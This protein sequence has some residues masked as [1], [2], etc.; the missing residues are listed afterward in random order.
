MIIW[1]KNRA[2]SADSVGGSRSE[3][4]AKEP[5]RRPNAGYEA[6]PTLPLAPTL[7]PVFGLKDEADAG[8]SATSDAGPADTGM[9]IIRNSLEAIPKGSALAFATDDLGAL[10]LAGAPVVRAPEFYRQVEHLAQACFCSLS[11]QAETG[12]ITFHRE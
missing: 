8:A 10:L 1:G 3:S 7:A 6:L 4:K 2:G 9:E 5:P 12:M 11:V